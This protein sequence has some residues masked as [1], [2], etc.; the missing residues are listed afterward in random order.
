MTDILIGDFLVVLFIFLRIIGMMVAAPVLGHQSIPMVARIFIAFVLAYITF[1]T[2]DKSKISFD[3]TLATI[4]V[5]SAKEIITGLIMGFALNFVFYGISYAGHMI[6]YE[7]GLMHAE[8]LNPMNEVNNNVVGEAI[9]YVSMM[10]FILINGH[11]HL[12]SAVVSS[13]K[14]IPIAKYTITESLVDLIVKYAFVVFTIAFKIA[15]PIM[16]SFFLI[17]IAEGIIARVIPHIQIF[18]I[19]QPLKIGLGLAFLSILA[20]LYIYVIKVF[21]NDYEY[22]LSEMINRMSV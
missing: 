3:V 11:H 4:F 17:H 10:L 9:F 12:I 21:L 6:G 7:M 1:M 18:Y 13:F 15:A 22:Q 14:I 20:P 5:N 2:I 8:V 16:V 19:S